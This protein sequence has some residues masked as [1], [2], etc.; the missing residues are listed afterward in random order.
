MYN[1]VVGER[2]TQ[3]EFYTQLQR[4]GIPERKPDVGL[5]RSAIA[6]IIAIR[7][8]HPKRNIIY[9]WILSTADTYLGHFRRSGLVYQPA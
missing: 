1:G 7:I 4:N 8:M 3:R 2:A 5:L 6:G 9:G